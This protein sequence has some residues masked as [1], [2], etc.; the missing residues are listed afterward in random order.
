[1]KK[2]YLIFL[3]ALCGNAQTS[4]I[5]NHSHIGKPQFNISEDCFSLFDHW[6]M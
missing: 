2:F 6:K 4:E 3:L 5:Y 1:M